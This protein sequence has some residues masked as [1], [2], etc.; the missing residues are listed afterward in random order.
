VP[1]DLADLGTGLT[2]R[3]ETGE[4]EATVIE[5]PFIDPRKETVKA[6]LKAGTAR[7]Y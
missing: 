6:D 5:K 2:V 4:Y 3:M 1:I 7:S